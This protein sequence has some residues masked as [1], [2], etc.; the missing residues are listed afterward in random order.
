MV[1]HVDFDVAMALVDYVQRPSARLGD[2]GLTD[3]TGVRVKLC[4]LR[5]RR[6]TV[7]LSE[8]NRWLSD[9]VSGKMSAASSM[10]LH[11]LMQ[12]MRRAANH[13]IGESS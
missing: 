2:W 12:L 7:N 6:N 5:S 9:Q 4:E 8:F 11:R 1:K 3:S 10:H 13:D